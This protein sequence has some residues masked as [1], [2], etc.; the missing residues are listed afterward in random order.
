MAALVL[1]PSLERNANAAADFLRNRLPAFL[2]ERLAAWAVPVFLR[3][4]PA[5]MHWSTTGT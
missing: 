4:H 2:G 5:H 1:A 3:V